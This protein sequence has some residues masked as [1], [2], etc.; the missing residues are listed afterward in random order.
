MNRIKQLVF[1]AIA[2]L[3]ASTAAAT[4]IPKPVSCVEHGKSF[5]INASTTIVCAS[6]DAEPLVGYL[7][8]YLPLK[9]AAAAPASNFIA[10]NL[11]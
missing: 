11:S 2:L 10:L 1:T 9:S 3:A 6:D 7:R 5:T 8:D 4:I